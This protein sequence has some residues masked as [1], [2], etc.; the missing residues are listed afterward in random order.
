[1]PTLEIIGNILLKFIL[2]YITVFFMYS[3][4]KSN[5]ESEP[6]NLFEFEPSLFEV[7]SGGSQN[8]IRSDITTLIHTNEQLEVT[9]PLIRNSEQHDPPSIDYE[10][11]SLMYSFTN[12]GDSC[13]V[14]KGIIR[15]QEYNDKIELIIGLETGVCM[16]DSISNGNS[17][18]Y[19]V[20][21]GARP[22]LFKYELNTS[23]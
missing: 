7:I 22:I 3:C 21:K 13:L 9:W 19:K 16:P 15:S 10:T 23:D 5:S 12:F 1:M 4:A 8:K 11:E 20:S 14:N 2:I 17:Y 6:T 18:F